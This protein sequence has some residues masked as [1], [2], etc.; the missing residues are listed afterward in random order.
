VADEHSSEDDATT[1]R[2]GA[3]ADAARD[4]T[5]SARM[6]SAEYLRAA[7][8]VRFAPTISP[9]LQAALDST[10]D[11]ARKALAAQVNVQPILDRFTK[12]AD[13]AA[14]KLAT[15]TLRLWDAQSAAS[16]LFDSPGIRAL[17]ARAAEL[18]SAWTSLLEG[19]DWTRVQR[20]VPANLDGLDYG[21]DD[22]VA[23]AAEGI[24]L[25]GV[26]STAI[27]SRLLAAPD[28]RAR[29]D[30]LG[31]SLL[32]LTE[33]CDEVLDQCITPV[34]RATVAAARESIAAIRAGHT[35]PAQAYLTSALDDLMHVAF[36][37]DTYIGFTSHKVTSADNIL[38]WN[39]R[40]GMVLGPIW[41]AH[42][43]YRPGGSAFIP[44]TYVRHASAHT[45]SSRQYSRRNTA[46]ALLL[47]TALALY[48]DEDAR[49][50]A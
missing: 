48:V 15:A 42:A 37:R 39:I 35:K 21:I 45:V 11:G 33:D 29:R 25:Y 14:P 49:T 16:A 1:D 34:T 32:R 46:Q 12:I 44:R 8:V 50:R 9:R 17:A 30:I 20:V 47:V 10:W 3:R 4:R 7:D 19:I 43:E 40:T 26:P 18:S 23:L 6:A 28:A 5:T 24:T 22:L 27:A 13:I 41:H 36:D 38:D 2:D 31:R